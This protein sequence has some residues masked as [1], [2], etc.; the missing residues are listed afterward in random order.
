LKSGAAWLHRVGK[1]CGVKLDVIRTAT[2]TSSQPPASAPLS[3]R[4][5]IGKRVRYGIRQDDLV[6]MAHGAAGVNNVRHVA[7]AFRRLRVN[8]GLAR[9]RENLGGIFLVKE[10]GADRILPD[11][12]NPVDRPPS[13]E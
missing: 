6:A 10:N 7:L 12:T 4:R 3:F 13:H 1:G 8:P 5:E 9:T 11:R 2:A